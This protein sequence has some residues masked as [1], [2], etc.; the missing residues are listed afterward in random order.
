[1]LNTLK[2]GHEVNTF[3]SPFQFHFL[4]PPPSVTVHPRRAGTCEMCG[5][6]RWA[7]ETKCFPAS[8]CGLVSRWLC[9]AA[10]TCPLARPINYRG[11]QVPKERSRAPGEHL[12]ARGAGVWINNDLN[13]SEP[14]DVSCWRHRLGNRSDEES[15]FSSTA[16]YSGLRCSGNQTRLESGI[17]SLSDIEWGEWGEERWQLSKH[18]SNAFKTARNCSERLINH[19]RDCLVSVFFFFF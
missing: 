16:L 11:K 13:F 7:E 12:T 5:E 9:R 18:Q 19:R 15:S 4:P 1:M 10:L 17:R 2:W 6:C 8:L 14:L 3:A